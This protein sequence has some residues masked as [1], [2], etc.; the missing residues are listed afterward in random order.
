MPT[1]DDLSTKLRDKTAVIGVVGLGYVGITVGAAL[2][3]AGFRVVGVD[4]SEERVRVLAAGACPLEGIEPGLAEL[5]EAVVR[6]ERLSV[7]TAHA[8][9]AQADVVLVAVE[10][11]VDAARRPRFDALRAACA[12]IGP[13]LREGALVV[14]ESTV[15][16]GTTTNV[17]APALEAAASK[18]VGETLF[19]GHSPE[20]LMPGKL[21]LNLRTLPRVCGGTTPETARAIATLYRTIVE[22]EIEE[23]DCVTA[24]LVKTAENTYRDVKIAFANELAQICEQTGADFRRVQRLVDGS[25]PLV[26]L[27]TAGAGV[28]GHCIPKDPWLLLDGAPGFS[29][30]VVTAA[31]AVNDRMPLHVA[32]LVE[33]ALAEREQTIAG[34]KIAVLGY[35]YRENSGDVRNSPSEALALHLRGRGADVVIHDPWVRAHK[36]DVYG[37]VCGA[38]AV[39]VMVA[40]D[41][42]RALDLPKLARALSTPVLVDARHVVETQDARAAGFVFRAL[43]RG[44]T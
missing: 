28:G 24:E 9:L 23:T 40:H 3:G 32:D 35:G 25:G 27:L 44:G 21:L 15:S 4:L 18:R 43:G 10:T 41:E 26:G 17:V 39:V 12:A 16:P 2:A 7:S 22:A 6:S 11:P 29:A 5:V 19:L 37:R 34:S 1:L 14:V 8:S 13:V 31:R 36:G 42:Y 30:R 38:N 20:R 33:R